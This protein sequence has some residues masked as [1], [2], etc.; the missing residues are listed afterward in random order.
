MMSS[1]A[2]TSA[3]PTDRTEIVMLDGHSGLHMPRWQLVPRFGEWTA[4]PCWKTRQ[5]S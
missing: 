3:S 2:M 5:K 4:A 1:P